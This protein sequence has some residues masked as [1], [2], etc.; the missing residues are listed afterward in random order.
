MLG[1]F[2]SGVSARETM[3]WLLLGAAGTVLFLSVTNIITY[4]IPPSPLSW[5]GP[6]AIYLVSFVLNFKAR[7][8]CPSWITG[9]IE[10]ILGAS[11]CL[12]CVVQPRAL[13][14]T[15][16]LVAYFFLLFALCMFCQNALYLT[17]PKDKNG[18]TAF[19]L[20]ISVG[21]FLGGMA[22][23]WIAPLVFTTPV[24]F[25]MG[26]VMVSLAMG[27]D[28]QRK[29]LGIF[30]WGL[31][32]AMVLLVVFFP[33]LFFPLDLSAMLII[34]G[35]V[36][37]VFLNLRNQA[38]AVC[39]ALS[40]L[41]IVS[42]LID[43]LRFLDATYS[44][45]IR[46]YY[47]VYRLMER[48]GYRMILHGTTIHGLQLLNPHRE[49]VPIGYYASRTPVGGFLKQFGSDL[50]AIGVVGL[51]S[52][53]LASYGRAGQTMDFYELDPAVHQMA[54]GP[55]TFLKGSQ[56][57]V[58]VIYG[59]ARI[60][61][62]RSGK[63]YDLLIVDAF[64]GDVVPAHLLTAEAV[65]IYKAHVSKG[66]VI[67]FHVTNRYLDIVPVLFTGAVRQNAHALFNMNV[68]EGDAFY[69]RWVA[70][71]WDKTWRDQLVSRLGW[72]DERTGLKVKK[73]RPWT[74]AHSS[75]LDL[76]TKDIWLSQFERDRRN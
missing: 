20:M 69:T 34:S 65:A 37:A 75:I 30:R 70:L 27:I 48:D 7:P 68:S 21:S 24:E 43:S 49:L 40:I 58:H 47:G 1:C 32:A 16:V 46:N 25:M 15:L 19:Y 53:E 2:S 31:I 57:D 42:P 4:E 39:L 26:L 73:I 33:L 8:F 71:T 23:T 52:G 11:A 59:D 56:A 13:P 9:R 10:L 28:V 41:F 64:S 36:L 12:Y 66:G 45:T 51:G 29:N 55:F 63:V 17:R 67:L 6:L 50:K 61:L 44:Q 54:K 22:V 72:Q 35:F 74:D 38:H 62:E 76:F 5:I 18:L 60:N 3:R 14:F